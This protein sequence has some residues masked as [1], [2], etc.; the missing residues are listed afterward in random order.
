MDTA[1]RIRL[2]RMI[3]K[4]DRNPRYNERLGLRNQSVCKLPKENEPSFDISD[5]AS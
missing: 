3:E 1:K 2:I 4:M 5:I